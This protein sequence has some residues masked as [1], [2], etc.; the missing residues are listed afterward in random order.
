MTFHPPKSFRSS[1]ILALL[2]GSATALGAEPA[3]DKTPLP[4]TPWPAS[5]PRDYTRDPITAADWVG[6]DGIIYPNWRWVGI[7]RGQPGARQRGIPSD[8]PVFAT[9]PANLAGAAEAENF[10]ASLEKLIR[11]CG[12]AGGGIIALPAGEFHLTRPLI[13]TS[14]RIVL[15]GA[16][17]GRSA[18]PEGRN[19]AAETRLRF[20][21]GFGVEGHDTV[22]IVTY[23]ESGRI[24]RDSQIALYAQA[25]SDSSSFAARGPGGKK[26]HLQEFLVTVT[27]EGKAPFVYAVTADPKDEACHEKRWSRFANGGPAMAAHI[28]AAKLPELS[29]VKQVTLQLKVVRRWQENGQPREETVTGKPVV[30]ACEPYDATTPAPVVALNEGPVASALLFLGQGGYRDVGRTQLARPA[31][32]GDTSVLVALPSVEEAARRGFVAGAVVRLNVSYSKKWHDL[33]ERDVGAAWGIPRD[34]YA[35][36]T[37]VTP[38]EGGLRF[39]L[40]QPLHFDFPINEGVAHTGNAVNERGATGATISALRMIEECGV[41]NLVLE[42]AHPVW[43]N[44]IHFKSARNCWVKNVRVERAG[45][46]PLVLDGAFNE[47]R[48]SEF[49]DPRWAYNTGEGSGYLSGSSFTLIDNI[50]ARNCR[51][52]PNFSGD[53]AGVIRNSRFFSSDLQWHNKWGRDHLVENCTVD[54]LQGTGAYGYAAFAQRNTANIHGPGMGPR[55]VIYGCDLIGPQ[56]GIFLGGKTEGALILFNRVIALN[57]PALVLRYHVF[58]GL[59]LGNTFAVQS[60][61]SPAVL[62]GDP[63]L[64]ASRRAVTPESPKPLTHPGLGAANPG[65]DFLFNTLYGGNGVFADGVPEFNRVRSPWRIEGGNRVLPWTADPPRPRPAMASVYETQL[66]HPDGFPPVDPAKALYRYAARPP[67]NAAPRNDGS[68]ALQVNFRSPRREPGEDRFHWS[69]AE[70]G[71]GWR[72][73]L[74]EP[75]GD[76]PGGLRYGWVNGTPR[77]TLQPRNQW[78]TA[79]VRYRTAADWTT[80]D[81]LEPVSKWKDNRDLAWRAELPPGRYRV[82]L[83]VGSQNEPKRFDAEER[84]LPYRQQNDFLLNGVLL[85]D[86][87]RSD[88]RQDA[89]WTEVV[90]GKDRLLE[91][92]PAG[93]AITPRVQFLQ[94]YSVR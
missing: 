61:F 66:A 27:P 57:G 64:K 58:N 14:N 36:L 44:G 3:L 8:L 30:F 75:F 85:S 84:P 79:D 51:H 24:T 40:E 37:G 1:W 34:Q 92:R 71:K 4:P 13:F 41:E 54:A 11:D 55:N 22:K 65:N 93:T 6:P 42:Q 72:D 9:V 83:A 7:Q 56:G 90:V 52:A 16:G 82:F 12:S 81:N 87:G 80:S 70:P 74:G 67:V 31:A 45:R 68:V 62:F 78:N 23:P 5:Y 69:G 88:A 35:V 33:I 50:Y 59:I 43:F 28:P 48:D 20:T 2:V 86:A 94:V 15:R 53:T 73:D 91:L 47:V 25:F 26:T 19:D 60:R 38:D 10:T 18:E 46:N 89:F 76:R 21:F 32:R 39:T 49:I 17:R 63:D 77:M 29:D